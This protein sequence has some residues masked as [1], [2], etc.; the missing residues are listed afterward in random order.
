MGPAIFG[1]KHKSCFL[2]S[3]LIFK[4]FPVFPLQP[5][6]PLLAGTEIKKHPIQS[7]EKLNYLKEEEPPEDS[8]NFCYL[9]SV[10]QLCFAVR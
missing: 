8:S 1:Q 7:E 5:N 3:L 9:L 10:R 6:P 2:Q 4:P